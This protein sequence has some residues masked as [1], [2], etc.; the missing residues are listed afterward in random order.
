[1]LMV[2]ES[3]PPQVMALP[4]IEEQAALPWGGP[5]PT[6]SGLGTVDRDKPLDIEL[7]TYQVSTHP[8]LS[9]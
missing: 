8:P 4:G 1:M 9:S 2:V 6:E 5:C 3:S 7:W